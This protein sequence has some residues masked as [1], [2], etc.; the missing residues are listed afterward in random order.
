MKYSKPHNILLLFFIF[1]GFHAIAQEKE[2]LTVESAVS[3]ALENNYQIK[4]ATND[5]KIDET[6]LSPGLAGMLPSVNAVADN[7]NGIQN[8][9]QTR[10]DGTTLSRDN[11]KNNNLNYGV[12]LDWTIFDGLR[13]FARYDQLQEVKK[14]GEAELQQ[15][16]LATVSDVM[17][18]YFNLVQQKQQLNALD[19]T[20]VI[21]SQ[22]VELANNRFSIGKAS[23]LEFL[24]AKVDENT[25]QTLFLRQQ[26]LFKNTKTRLNEII[27]RNVKTDFEVVDLISIDKSLQLDT[28]E[29]QTKAQN[30]Q[31]QAQLINKRIAELELKQIKGNRYPKISAQA[32]YLFGDSESSLGFT[33]NNKT[34]GFNYGFSAT[35]NLFDGFN[36]NRNEKIAKIQIENSDLLIAQQTQ[37]LLSQLSTAFETYKTNLKLMELEV[38]N[39]AIA[40]ENLDITVAKYRIGTIPTIEFRTA[41]LNYINAVLRSSNSVYEAKLSEITLQELAGNLSL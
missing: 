35:L 12:E 16:V 6:S 29:E 41:Q 19:S 32:G 8:I 28:L 27:G 11:A 36:Q 26:E 3:I 22:R 38:N 37:T 20:L 33:T 25:D 14:L 2:M 40:K 7:N 1:L 30:P 31:L 21:S 15:E 10:S 4:M 18:T 13:M 24:N 34:R 17:T 9:T 5:L 23:K 39:E